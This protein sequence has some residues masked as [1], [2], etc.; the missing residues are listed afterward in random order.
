MPH[1]DNFIADLLLSIKAIKIQPRN[2]FVWA[3]GWNSPIY[4]DNNKI[5]SS[6]HL[7]D[8][9]KL[10]LATTIAENFPDCEVIAGV[11]PNAIAMGVLV[12]DEL[13]IPFVFVHQHPKDHGLENM[14]EGDLKIRKKV[15]VIDD[16]V[17]VGI[18]TMTAINA[19]KKSGCKVQGL[20]SIFDFELKE[21]QERF[22]TAEVKYI[23]LCTLSTLLQHAAQIDYIE[24]SEAKII[25]QWQKS[26]A[27]WGREG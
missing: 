25:K 18:H 27:K 16:Q 6:P 19:I 22:S 23:P 4:C 10:E 2:P 7:R 9:I 20:V 8:L 11:A 26:P 21:A 5:N 24:P 17:N 14:I 1:I 12:A 13:G 15:V 3:N